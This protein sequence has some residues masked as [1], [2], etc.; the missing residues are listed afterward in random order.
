MRPVLD[1]SCF[2]VENSLI[3]IFLTH[4]IMFSLRIPLYHVLK[5]DIY[6]VLEA[7]KRTLWESATARTTL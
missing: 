2:S 6:V 3:K 4:K 5:H 7:T 1:Q